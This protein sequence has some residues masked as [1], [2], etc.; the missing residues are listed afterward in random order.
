MGRDP[1]LGGQTLED[2]YR[3]FAAWRA[4]HAREVLGEQ[5]PTNGVPSSLFYLSGLLPWNYFAQTFQS[6][7]S[8]LVSST[9]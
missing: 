7:S 9:R 1:E 8:T 4:R 3:E 2:E 6:T 5:I